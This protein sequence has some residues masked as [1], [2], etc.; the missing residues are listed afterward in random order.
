MDGGGGGPSGG[1]GGSSRGADEDEGEKEMESLV[2]MHNNRRQARSP[3]VDAILDNS[4]KSPLISGEE[5]YRTKNH[6]AHG[7]ECIVD[8]GPA[9][10]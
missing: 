2:P 7:V 6:H 4:V 3:E 10:M 1:P 8:D 5:W 9:A